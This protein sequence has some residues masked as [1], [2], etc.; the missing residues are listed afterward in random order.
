MFSTFSTVLAHKFPSQLLHT[1][2]YARYNTIQILKSTNDKRFEN[3]LSSFHSG[4]S[5]L[6]VDR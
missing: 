2:S 4:K 3:F 1:T 6:N 5:I